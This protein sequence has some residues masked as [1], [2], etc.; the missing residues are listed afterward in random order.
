[1]GAHA[2]G[3]FG[4]CHGVSSLHIARKLIYDAITESPSAGSVSGKPEATE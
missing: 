3:Q 4:I 1:M 2:T